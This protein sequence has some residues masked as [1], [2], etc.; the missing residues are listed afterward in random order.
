MVLICLAC[1]SGLYVRTGP[2]AAGEGK[3]E[4]TGERRG[5]DEGPLGA[6]VAVQGGAR[7]EGGGAGVREEEGAG[8]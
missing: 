1:M 5:R 6:K 3:R 4:G 7:R 2:E 8:G